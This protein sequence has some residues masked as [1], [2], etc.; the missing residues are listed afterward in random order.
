MQTLIKELKDY[1]LNADVANASLAFQASNNE[2][3]IESFLPSSYS[4]EHGIEHNVIISKNESRLLEIFVRIR[5]LDCTIS[6]N[7]NFQRYVSSNIGYF[8]DDFDDWENVEDDSILSSNIIKAI[9][10]MLI[11]I[12]EDLKNHFR[13]IHDPIKK[14]KQSKNDNLSKKCIHLNELNLTVVKSQLGQELFDILLSKG[15]LA[16]ARYNH[17]TEEIQ[18]EQLIFNKKEKDAQF[19][20]IIGEEESI[21]SKEKAKRLIYSSYYDKNTTQ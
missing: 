16:L 11:D 5:E 3:S 15:G 21:I 8:L 14:E 20:W 7:A 19:L 18:T 12:E 10:H 13:S 4:Y 1:L 2:F 9:N 17:K 6:V